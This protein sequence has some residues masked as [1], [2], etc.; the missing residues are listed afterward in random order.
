MK[1]TQSDLLAPRDKTAT[2]NYIRSKNKLM[3]QVT[4]N[5]Y[6]KKMHIKYP[7]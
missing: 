4:T 7:H 6:Y 1:A 5:F 2:C 3:I